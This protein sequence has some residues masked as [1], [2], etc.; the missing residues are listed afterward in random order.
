M[1]TIE[2][3]GWK[4]SRR[5]G[6]GDRELV[7]AGLLQV[8]LLSE[9]KTISQIEACLA[10]AK[11]LQK[12]LRIYVNCSRLG[13]SVSEQIISNTFHNY[14]DHDFMEEYNITPSRFKWVLGRSDIAISGSGDPKVL[15]ELVLRAWNENNG[16]HNLNEKTWRQ[17]EEFC[18]QTFPEYYA[19]DEVLWRLWTH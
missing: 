19:E 15:T 14:R 3:D 4:V 17:T 1:I 7:R 6:V 9:D 10:A 16:R 11:K 2:K 13:R 5:I 18:Q 12:T 8:V